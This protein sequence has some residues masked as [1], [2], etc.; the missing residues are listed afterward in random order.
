MRIGSRS[1]LAESAADFF[2]FDRFI[3]ELEPSFVFLANVP[4]I[5]SDGA[6]VVA[7]DW[8]ASGMT[9]AGKLYPLLRSSLH[10]S[11]NDG[12]F[13]PTP[14]C[15]GRWQTI[16]LLA[17]ERK[18]ASLCSQWRREEFGRT[19]RFADADK[20]IRSEEGAAKATVAAA[21]MG[22]DLPAA[23]GGGRLKSTWVEWLMGYPS[24]WTVCAHWA[25]PSRRNAPGKRH[26]SGFN[27]PL[28]NA[29]DAITIDNCQFIKTFIIEMIFER[30]NAVKQNES[31]TL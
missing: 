30:G 9:V 2:D 14:S 5:R 12:G 11:D 4:A 16:S 1:G 10:I 26:A 13:W 25:M 8:P 29:H 19:P 28:Q 22:C 3:G 18:G 23:V 6:D 27:K 20:G 17:R 21:R 7:E 15:H 31:G 24:G